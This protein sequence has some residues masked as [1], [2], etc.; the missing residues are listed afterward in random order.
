VVPP[1]NLQDLDEPAPL[2][3]APY[4]PPLVPPAAPSHDAYLPRRLRRL[5]ELV[6]VEHQNP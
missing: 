5:A 1:S 2:P 3:P 4:G 6:V